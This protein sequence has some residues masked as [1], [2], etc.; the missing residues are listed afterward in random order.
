MIIFANNVGLFRVSAEG[1]EPELL[2]RSYPGKGELFYAWPEILPGNRAALFTVARDAPAAGFDIAAVDLE[3][4]EY[5]T[6][7]PGGSGARY[8]TTGHL[9]YADG[10]ALQAVPFDLDTVNIDGDPVTVVAGPITLAR[11]GGA[12]FG[13]STTGT[14]V[15]VPAPSRRGDTLV[16]VDA[17]VAR[18][19][20]EHRRRRTCIPA[21]RPDGTRVAVDVRDRGNNRDIY[22]WD[23]ARQN[24]TRLTDHPTEDLFAVWSRDS[25]RIFFS[26]NQN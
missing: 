4:L 7:L 12:E 3:T 24:M 22:I 5:Q 9:I 21:S 8:A 15:Y 6:L 2:I 14:L 1:G 13:L 20:S 16:W 17:R 23:F 26:S 11:E 10:G 18:R 25:Q 19:P